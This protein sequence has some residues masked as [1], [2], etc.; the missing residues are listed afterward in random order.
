MKVLKFG[1]SSVANSNNIKKVLDI[2][3]SQSKDQKVAVVVSAFG[4]TTDNLLKIANLATL[5]QEYEQLLKETEQ[6][7]LEVIKELIPIANQSEVISYVKRLFN[8]LETLFEGCNLLQEL[9]PKTLAT[10]ASF[11]ELLSSYIISKAAKE[12]GLNSNY[13][14]SKELIVANG[15][16]QSATVN[17]DVTFSPTSKGTPW[18]LATAL[19][20]PSIIPVR[21]H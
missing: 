12:V 18:T 2:V 6:H 14:D 4:K 11:G 1:G 5:N 7:H 10:I 13:K 20:T 17:F 15:S 21:V 9:T 19:G 3:N 16:Y 8:H